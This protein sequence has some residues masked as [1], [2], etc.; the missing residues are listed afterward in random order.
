M[1]SNKLSCQIGPVFAD[2]PFAVVFACMSN[3]ICVRKREFRV[4]EF[5]HPAQ[6]AGCNKR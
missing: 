4:F 5:F 6:V 1:D 2:P 3:S